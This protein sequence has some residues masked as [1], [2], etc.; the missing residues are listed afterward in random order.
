MKSFDLRNTDRFLRN[1]FYSLGKYE[2]PV[3]YKQDIETGSIS[4]LGFQNTRSHDSKNRD[5]SIHFFM[6]DNKFQCVWNNPERYIKKLSQYKYVMS[7]DFSMY[8]NMPLPSQIWNVFRRRWCSAYWQSNGLTVIPSVTWSDERSFDFCFDGIEKGSILSVSTIGSRKQ[9]KVYLKGFIEMCR[10][11]EPEKVLCYYKPFDEMLN[12][13]EIITLP[14]EG[15]TV[16]GV[17]FLP[18]HRETL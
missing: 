7:P 2:M 12:V 16:R 11:L 4:L 13:A 10:R 1:A 17:N 6:D 5:K 15:L 18:E 3:I 9:K 8:T 14:Y